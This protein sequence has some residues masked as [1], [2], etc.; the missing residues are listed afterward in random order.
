MT[1]IIINNIENIN[2]LAM[3]ANLFKKGKLKLNIS[4]LA[5]ELNKDRKTIWNSYW[6]CIRGCNT[7]Y[8]RQHWQ[9]SRRYNRLSKEK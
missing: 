9:R 4:K 6:N 1:E 2:D 7:K 5:R 8:N 3:F